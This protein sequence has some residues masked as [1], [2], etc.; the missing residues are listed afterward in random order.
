MKE[1]AIYSTHSQLFMNAMMMHGSYP[2]HR[3]A[4]AGHKYIIEELRKRCPDSDCLV[5]KQGKNMLHIIIAK[6]GKCRHLLS[7]YMRKLDRKKRHMFKEIYKCKF[8][9]NV[10]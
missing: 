7:V 1:H 8:L 2:I 6:S 4:Q 9:F 10:Y 5:N 3:A